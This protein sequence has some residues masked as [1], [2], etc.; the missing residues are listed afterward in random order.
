MTPDDFKQAWECGGEKLV[1]FPSEVVATLRIPEDQRTFLIQP[2]LPESA[3]PYLTFGG[4]HYIGM[5]SAAELWKASNAFKRYRVIGANG[6]GDPICVDEESEG[7]IVYLN[8]DDEMKRC[9]MNSNVGRLASTLLAFREVVQETQK[10][11]GPDAYLDGQVP[12]DVV[13]RFIVQMDEIDPS[14]IKANTF[15]FHS[16]TGEGI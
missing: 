15:W 14:A 4:K 16:V 10:R 2:G 6:F 11:G 3:A 13:D 7:V 8:H 1:T 12:S 5:P 9:F